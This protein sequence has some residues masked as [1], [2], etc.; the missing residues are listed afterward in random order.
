M[1]NCDAF[2]TSTGALRLEIAGT[3]RDTIG[4]TVFDRIVQQVRR[5]KDEAREFGRDIEVF[6]Q[7]QVICRPRNGNVENADW[8][9]KGWLQQ[10]GPNDI[11]IEADSERTWI[12]KVI[13]RRQSLRHRVGIIKRC[14]A[15]AQ[16]SPRSDDPAHYSPTRSSRHCAHK[17]PDRP[18]RGPSPRARPGTRRC[19]QSRTGNFGP[20]TRPPMG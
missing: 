20:R 1:R 11:R 8:A 10:F 14:V 16:T 12:A 4:V 2:S 13:G 3:A 17:R 5:I 18:G 9:T 15:A 19:C 7:G 6:T